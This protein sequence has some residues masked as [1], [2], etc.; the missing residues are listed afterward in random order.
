MVLHDLLEVV[1]VVAGAQ[2]AGG[3]PP[4]QAFIEEPHGGHVLPKGDALSAAV[5]LALGALPLQA[6][7]PEPVLAPVLQPALPAGGVDMVLHLFAG[8]AADGGGDLVRHFD[9]FGGC[10]RETCSVDLAPVSAAEVAR[11]GLISFAQI[12]PNI[13]ATNGNAEGVPLEN[14]SRA[15]FSLLHGPQ[16]RRISFSLL[17]ERSNARATHIQ[18]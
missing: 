4:P 18:Q 13:V 2:V 14:R 17:S 15:S 1:E 5:L 7:E 16:T 9:G 10:D 3:K 12:L 6:A 8:D 11:H